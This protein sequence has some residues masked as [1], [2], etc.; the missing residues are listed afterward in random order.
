MFRVSHR[1]IPLDLLTNILG[2]YPFPPTI[3]SSLRTLAIVYQFSLCIF[4]LFAFSRSLHWAMV[5][6]YDEIH[7]KNVLGLTHMIAYSVTPFINFVMF[8]NRARFDFD[9][10]YRIMFDRTG[11]SGH[12]NR[13]YRPDDDVIFTIFNVMLMILYS[14]VMVSR[15]AANF[16]DIF[17][18]DYVYLIVMELWCLVPVLRYLRI[19]LLL[20]QWNERIL[21]QLTACYNLRVQTLWRHTAFDVLDD[22]DSAFS[23]I[24]TQFATTTTKNTMRTLKN[25]H[26]DVAYLCFSVV[27][28]EYGLS[29]IMLIVTYSLS[30]VHD[31]VLL[32][33][34]TSR[35]QLIWTEILR[36]AHKFFLVICV[37]NAGQSATF[38]VSCAFYVSIIFPRL[39]LEKFDRHKYFRIIVLCVKPTFGFRYYNSLDSSCVA[40]SQLESVRRQK[41]LVNTID[42]NNLLLWVDYA[43]KIVG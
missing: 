14:F 18:Y 37:F 4:Y 36:D 43:R 11:V 28:R 27:P 3:E 20:L 40:R 16:P 8:A 39:Q 2:L 38:R 30:F 41:E 31:I 24:P 23:K 29:I 17:W 1:N 35:K 33:T 9:A 6:E 34:E 15:V 12:R 42:I 7:I 32:M 22:D 26:K 21:K 10:W 19:I 25:V 5:L 13:Y